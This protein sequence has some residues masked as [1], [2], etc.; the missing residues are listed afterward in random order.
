MPSNRGLLQQDAT[1]CESDVSPLSLRVYIYDTVSLSIFLSL[2]VSHSFYISLSLSLYIFLSL[3]HFKY[4]FI[5][6]LFPWRTRSS[7]SPHKVL[8]L[9][10]PIS[11]FTSLSL[12]FSHSLYLP[13]SISFSLTMHCT[14]HY[15]VRRRNYWVASSSRLLKMIR[16]FAEYG[17]FYRALLRKGLGFFSLTIHCTKHWK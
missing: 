12:S 16:L 10:S 6:F 17:L 4:L 5:S 9:K 14:T 13:L 15:G 2:I 11:H 7:L 8:T 3:S 1:P